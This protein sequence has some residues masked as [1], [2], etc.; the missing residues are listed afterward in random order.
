VSFRELSAISSQPGAEP[1]AIR[2]ASKITVTEAYL[3]ICL[4][5]SCPASKLWAVENRTS[6]MICPACKSDMIVVERSKI[7]LDYC[8]SCGGVW[9]DSGELDLLLTSLGLADCS[10]FISDVLGSGGVK[11]AEKMR[12]CPVCSQ[13]MLKSHLGEQ[14][15]VLVDACRRGDGLWLDSGELDDLLTHL[16]GRQSASPDCDLKVSTFLQEVFQAR[17]RPQRE[18]SR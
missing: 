10:Q 13:R 8:A 12:K 4:T 1:I 17:E 16:A 2:I 3:P 9:F 11:S 15:Q 7:E 6:I 14:P 5:Q 18:A